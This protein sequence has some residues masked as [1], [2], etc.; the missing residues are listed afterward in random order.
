VGRREVDAP[1]F[2]RVDARYRGLYTRACEVF[3]A[4]DRV[5]RVEVSGSIADG[6][7]D[8][9]SDL[10]L[11][12][13]VRDASVGP[14]LDDWREWMDKIT[15]TVLLDRPIAPFIVNAVTDEGLTFDVSVWTESAPEWTPPPGFTVG[16]VSGRR[17]DNHA[18]AVAY[19]VEERLRGLA[20]PGI[21]LAKRGDF[22]LH[23]ATLGH[24]IGLLMEVLLAEIDAVPDDPRH[25]ERSLTDEQRAVFTSLPPVSATESLVNFEMALARETLTRARPLFDRFGLEWPTALEAVAAR[26]VRDHLGLEFD[27]LHG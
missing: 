3:G 20:G 11:K 18:D 6:T 24:T 12:V 1:D 21:R 15:P 9:W 8:E 22:V 14:F 27:W 7:A 13:I 23:L 25:P 16:F 5:V 19:A 17:F 26:N 10:D 2:S 4:D